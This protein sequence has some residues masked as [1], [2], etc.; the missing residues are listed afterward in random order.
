MFWPVASKKKALEL[1]IIKDTMTHKGIDLELL[2][3]L[4][5]KE[6]EAQEDYNPE[7]EELKKKVGHYDRPW[8]SAMKKSNSVSKIEKVE[9]TLPVVE[10]K[11]SKKVAAQP[12]QPSQPEIKKSEEEDI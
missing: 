4:K 10:T 11:Q 7:E 1:Q 12:P 5:K 8:R 3:Q 9:E 6:R 2:A